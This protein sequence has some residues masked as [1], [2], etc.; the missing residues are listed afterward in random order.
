PPWA[1]GLCSTI[2]GG[3]LSESCCL[4]RRSNRETWTHA[5]STR[6]WAAIYKRTR[7][8]FPDS[9]DTLMASY[10]G[11]TAIRIVQL[12]LDTRR[13]D[14][15]SK[16][17][18]G[19]TPLSWAAENGHEGVVQLLLDTGRI[20][21]ESKDSEYGRTPLSWA[22][23]NGHERV[24]QLLLDT[25]RVDVE[26]KDSEYGQTP[27]SWAAENGHEGVVQLL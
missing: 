19:R 20:D 24:I 23:R 22:A 16:D 13:V 15:E 10:L 7:Y 18:E 5:L 14:V 12:L 6:K 26:S 9:N 25:G 17:S 11:L 21:M 3:S 2:L 1:Y 8:E 4:K 27:L